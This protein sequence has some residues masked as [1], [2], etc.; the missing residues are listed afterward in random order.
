[1]GLPGGLAGLVGV[2]QR[3][4]VPADRV[5]AGAGLVDDGEVGRCDVGFLGGGGGDGLGGR[6]D[7]VPGLVA[8]GGERQDQA[9][10]VCLFDVSDG[11]GGAEHIG[12]HAAVAFGAFP[13]RPVQRLAG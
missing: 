5:A 7:V 8:D 13:G 11:E 10:G 6:Q 12:G 2:D 9:L 1:Q 3:P 4:A